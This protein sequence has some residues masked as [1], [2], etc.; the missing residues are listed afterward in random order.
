[1]KKDKTLAVMS[2]LVEA[3]ESAEALLAN[4]FATSFGITDSEKFRRVMEELENYD[5]TFAELSQAKKAGR[6][7]LAAAG[8]EKGTGK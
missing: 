2:S 5:R 3:A 1:M 7:I 4:C 6:A 8:K